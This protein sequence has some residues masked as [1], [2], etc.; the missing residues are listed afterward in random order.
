MGFLAL[1]ETKLETISDNL[2]YSLWGSEDCNWFYLPSVGASGGILSIWGTS[3]SKLICTFSGEGFVGVCLEW[4][5]LK[6]ICFV[7]NVCS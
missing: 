2:C 1:Q 6:T 3:N 5:V 4:E 7:I